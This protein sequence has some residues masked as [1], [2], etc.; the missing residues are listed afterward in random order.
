MQR[1]G[2]VR[3]G[4]VGTGGVGGVRALIDHRR[5]RRPQGLLRRLQPALQLAL[6]SAGLPRCIG[7]RLAH[8]RELLLEPLAVGGHAGVVR[9]EGA[10]VLLRAL[11]QLLRRAL[12]R[13]QLRRPLPLLRRGRALVL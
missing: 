2:G 9:L 3:A 1:A 8:R 13:I 11:L 10:H 5:H 6:S 4:G 7:R 12:R